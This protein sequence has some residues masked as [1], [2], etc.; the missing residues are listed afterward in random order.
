MKY[1]FII[2]ILLFFSI[3]CN[4]NKKIK[5]ETVNKHDFHIIPKPKELLELKGYFQLN[6]YTHFIYPKFNENIREFMDLIQNN[7]PFK[8]TGT[9]SSS[10]DSKNSI[11]FYLDDSIKNDEAYKLEITPAFIRLKAKTNTGL[12][13]AVQSLIQ[14]LIY[15]TND[16]RIPALIINDEPRFKYRGLH[17]D[18]C[19]HF[20]PPEFVKKYIDLMS[21]Y[22]FNRFHWH[23]TEDQ[24]W[25]I[26]IKKYPKL[27]EIGAFRDSTLIG[28]YSDIPRRF[29]KKRYGGFYTQEEVKDIVKYAK[30]KHVT[31][32][33]EIEMPGHSR[34]ALDA[35]TELACTEGP[36]SVMPLW[37]ISKDIYCPYEKTITF[38]EDV[39]NEVMDLFTGK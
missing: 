16:N 12:F 14:I 39:L 30:S 2:F 10:R 33:P 29:N 7:L 15:D 23:L 8:L 4:T 24:G 37:G 5:I 18:V 1:I 20:F 21:R 35:C 34:A 22:K 25:R 19:R 36:F 13:Y 38:L 17:L 11:G 26:E 3:S 28:R 32:I 27:T 9:V 6:K 31:I